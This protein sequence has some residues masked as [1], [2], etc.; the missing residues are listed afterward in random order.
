MLFTVTVT[1][2]VFRVEILNVCVCSDG[3]C[4]SVC[5]SMCLSICESVSVSLSAWSTATTDRGCHINGRGWGTM[6]AVP[7]PFRHG[8]PALCGSHPLVTTY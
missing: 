2:F 6:A 5:L 4:E 3:C 7:P 8:E 1:V